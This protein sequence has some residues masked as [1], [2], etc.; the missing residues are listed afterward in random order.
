VKSEERPIGRS[1]SCVG[2]AEEYDAAQERGE[3]QTAGGDRT[4]I[5]P[6]QDNAPLPAVFMVAIVPC[7]VG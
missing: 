4:S 1:E 6:D 2:L 7:L 3:V 5:V